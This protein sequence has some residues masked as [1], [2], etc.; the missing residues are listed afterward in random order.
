MGIKEHRIPVFLDT[1]FMRGEDEEAHFVCDPRADNGQTCYGCAGCVDEEGEFFAADA[2][3]VC[4]GSH[5]RADDDG[6]RIII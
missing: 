2:E 1:E 3:A 5:R 6:I 4:D